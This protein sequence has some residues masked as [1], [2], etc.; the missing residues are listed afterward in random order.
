MDKLC[1]ECILVI[2]FIKSHENVLIRVGDVQSYSTIA[3]M[4]A[5]DIEPIRPFEQLTHDCRPIATRQDAFQIQIECI[6]ET[7]LQ[8]SRRQ[9]D[10]IVNHCMNNE[11]HKFEYKTNYPVKANRL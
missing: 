10:A 3:L 5:V 2:E 1:F 11:G 9:T 7:K 6:S 4:R 8:E